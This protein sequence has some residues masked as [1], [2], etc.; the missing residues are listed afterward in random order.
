M[1]LFSVS[2]LLVGDTSRE[3]NEQTPQPSAL[4]GGWVWERALNFKS[5]RL[6][7]LWVFGQCLSA[8]SYIWS[9]CTNFTDEDEP[10]CLSWPRQKLCKLWCSQINSLCVWYRCR[11]DRRQRKCSRANG[12]HSLQRI[13]PGE[14][15]RKMKQI[16]TGILLQ[17]HHFLCVQYQ[18]EKL[19]YQLLA[20]CL[21]SF[22]SHRCLVQAP[23]VLDG[24]EY[25]SEIF[26]KEMA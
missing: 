23:R 24:G 17:K 16:Y 8:C 2:L 3:R 10:K 4:G 21:K 1:L 6:I 13:L 5:T 14:Q 19:K 9:P 26:L 22:G 11:S 18:A 12:V 25:I 20:G 15:K 7:N